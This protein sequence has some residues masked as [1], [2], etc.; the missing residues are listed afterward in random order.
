MLNLIFFPYILFFF[1]NVSLVI[2]TD[3]IIVNTINVKLIISTH[4]CNILHT[5]QFI[6]SLPTH[7]I[8]ATELCKCTFQRK[9]LKMKIRSGRKLRLNGASIFKKPSPEWKLNWFSLNSTVDT[10]H[11]SLRACN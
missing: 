8:R 4:L 2:F 5:N 9:L 10:L 1:I 6:I 7:R 3:E 11:L